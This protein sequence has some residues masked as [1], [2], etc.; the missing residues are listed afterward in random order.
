MHKFP[1]NLSLWKILRQFESGDAS[2]GMSLNFTARGVAKITDGASSGG[3]QLY[4]EAP[5]LNIMGR[6]F[7]SFVDLQKTLSQL[8]YNSGSVLMRLTYRRTDQ[9]LFEAMEEIGRLFQ[10]N[11]FGNGAA[12]S[13]EASKAESAS[14]D[15][16]VAEE[17]ALG[18]ITAD[19]HPSPETEA[20]ATIP[21]QPAVGQNQNEGPTDLDPEGSKET[22]PYKP[23]NVFLAPSSTVPA[24]TLASVSESD[25]TPSIAHAQLHQTRLQENS[26]NKRLLSDKEIGEKAAAEE[27]K[28]AAVKSVLIKVRF[29]DN[30]SSDWEIGPSTTGS[31]LYE[32]VRHVM[33]NKNESFRLVLPG[34]KEV[35]KDTES[36]KN[37]LVRDY[38]LS[39]R[40]LINLVWEDSVKAEVRRQ[41]FLQATVAQ[42]A[43]D[44]RVPDI[45]QVKDDDDETSLSTSQPKEEKKGDGVAKKL[46]KW[47][48]MGKK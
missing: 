11:E 25:F 13:S 4:Y 7:T 16:P 34:T 3:G 5:V 20:L 15:A 14:V 24:A 33:A 46:P 8:G 36:S 12:D 42:T 47:F 41:P 39:G 10:D 18:D 31:F 2:T 35:I 44:I 37:R 28:V 9:T 45:P 17:T 23:V 38:K 40:V 48:K 26:R 1:S 32:A 30:T 21:S 22:D 29:P 19:G 27:A 43:Q 6:E